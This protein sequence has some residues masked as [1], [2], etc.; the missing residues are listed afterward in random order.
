M[1]AE[2]HHLLL[3]EEALEVLPR[4]FGIRH[5]VRVG[6]YPF[7]PVLGARKQR[8]HEVALRRQLYLDDAAPEA[9]DPA[10]LRAPLELVDQFDGRVEAGKLTVRILRLAGD[11]VHDD[12]HRLLAIVE[13]SRRPAQEGDDLAAGSLIRDLMIKALHH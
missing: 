4:V 5:N 13:N 12:V 6:A 8:D 11:T 9:S 7:H 10:V 1:L 3:G 2:H